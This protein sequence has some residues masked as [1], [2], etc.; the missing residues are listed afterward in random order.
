M[1]DI[2][3]T[4]LTP[5]DRDILREPAVGGLILFS[6]NF[7]SPDQ[8]AE[9]VA[10]VRSL[11]K[12]PILI[13]V[14]HEGGRVQRFRDGFTTIPPMRQIGHYYDSDPQAALELSR[15]VAWLIGVELRAYRI[16]LSFSPCLDLDW[17]VNSAIGDRAFHRDPEAVVQLATRYCRGLRE[18]GMA[19]VGKHFPGH[20][21]VTADSH[22]RLPVDR[23]EFGQLLDD[24][25]PYD[26]LLGLGL[27]PAV[28]MAHV[29]YAEAD[30]LPA[31]LSPFWIRRQLRE[32]LGFDGAVFSDDMSMKA[33]ADYGSMARRARMALEAGS[34]MV[35]ICNDRP[36]AARAV[37]ALADYSNPPSLVRLARLHGSA[38][39]DRERL[40]ASVEWQSTVE[41]LRLWTERPVLELDA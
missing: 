36:A 24:M 2:E 21:A 4:E 16:D 30:R 12:P 33:T 29:V 37:A 17:G 40:H 27:L 38:G 39:P 10:E 5:T 8:L 14:D 9:L 1:L 15:S 13:A 18:A 23:R 6:R 32:Q 34:D 22:E 11:R 7:A 35:V 31:S 41:R 20:G 25:R 3:G 28:M 26:S 19:A